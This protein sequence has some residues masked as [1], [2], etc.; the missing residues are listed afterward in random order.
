MTN[1]LTQA[2]EAPDFVAWDTGGPYPPAGTYHLVLSDG[3]EIIR[4]MSADWIWDDTF[5]CARIDVAFLAC[6]PPSEVEET[7]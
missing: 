1:N 5:G 2:L 6:T 3:R 4:P 7:Q